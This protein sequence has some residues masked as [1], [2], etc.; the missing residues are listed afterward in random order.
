MTTRA[1]IYARISKDKVGAGLGVDRQIKN[2]KELADRLG[3]VVAVAHT[4]NDMSAYRGKPRPGYKALLE[5]IGTGRVDAV[6]AWHND[7]LHRSPVELEHYIAVCE[8]RSIPTHFVMAGPLDLSTASG[9]MTARITGAVARA[10]VEHM[11][12]RIKAQKARAIADGRWIGGARPFGFT[13]DGMDL[14]PEE[15]ELIRDGVRRVLAGESVYSIAARWR[16]MGVRTPRNSEMALG[17]VTK[18]LARPRNAGYRVHRGQVI[19]KGGWPSIISDDE[20]D[21]VRDILKHPHRNTYSG[22]R[23]LKWLGSGLYRCGKCGADLRSATA[24]T[25]KTTRA[26]LHIYRCR[27]DSHLTIHAEPADAYVLKTMCELLDQYGAAL[28]PAPPDNKEHVQRLR[29]EA[30]AARIRYH[31]LEDMFGDGEITREGLARQKARIEAKLAE[32]H[33]ELDQYNDAS[34]LAGIADAASPSTAFLDQPVARQR[35]IVDALVTVTIKPSE[36]GRPRSLDLS[37]V[38]IE[39]RQI[40]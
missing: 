21:A 7:R 39:E 25:R 31:Q 18:V 11:S 10:E 32:I 34:P 27:T 12:E 20:Y 37:R 16:A 35:A 38:R 13:R 30:T 28:L 8:G 4:D 6:L 17:E 19:G 3:W 26:R 23:T 22:V 1:A 15:A 33:Q 36:R 5:D 14:D 9:R 24:T 40:S 29:D 2:C